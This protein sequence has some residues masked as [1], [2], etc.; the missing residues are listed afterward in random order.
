MSSQVLTG[1]HVPPQRIRRS[2]ATVGGEASRTSSETSASPASNKEN[3]NTLERIFALVKEETITSSEISP[4][5]VAKQEN[6]KQREQALQ[7][8]QRRD[9][10][11]EQAKMRDK[12]ALV[13]LHV[14]W[15]KERKMRHDLERMTDTLRSELSEVQA[16]L[17]ICEREKLEDKARSNKII[18]S[19]KEKILHEMTMREN[20]S[21][22]IHD[23]ILEMD[24]ASEKVSKNVQEM[25]EVGKLLMTTIEQSA[26]SCIDEHEGEGLQVSDEKEGVLNHSHVTDCSERNQEEANGSVETIYDGAGPEGLES[27]NDEELSD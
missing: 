25:R 11:T 4:S 2:P 7:R 8:S 5:P 24:K 21:T 17:K 26:K 6:T 10:G 14:E 22:E 1:P 16:K 18:E 19:L 9:M 20:T 23:D 15:N 13:D 12:Q 27:G 3:V